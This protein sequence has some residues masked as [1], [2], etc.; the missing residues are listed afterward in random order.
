MA[1]KTASLIIL[2]LTIN[3]LRLDQEYKS[4]NEV[5]AMNTVSVPQDNV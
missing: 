3:L 5:I 2:T 4:E 1:E